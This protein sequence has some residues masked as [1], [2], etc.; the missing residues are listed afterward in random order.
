MW[1][2]FSD[3]QYRCNSNGL[4]A[5]VIYGDMENFVLTSV[6]KKNCTYESHNTQRISTR[7]Q[8]IITSIPKSYLRC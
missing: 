2:T 6:I 8:K 7:R 4:V 5:S 1:K 3:Q